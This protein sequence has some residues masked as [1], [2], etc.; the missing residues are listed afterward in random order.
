MS[1][2]SSVGK[3]NCRIDVIMVGEIKDRLPRPIGVGQTCY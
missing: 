2:D 1:Y 3:Q